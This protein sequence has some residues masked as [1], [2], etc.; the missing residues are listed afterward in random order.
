MTG[1]MNTKV[2]LVRCPRCRLVLPELAEVPVYKC[3]GC[4]AILQAKNR[5]REIQDTGSHAHEED[6]TR[7]NGLEHASEDKKESISSID[8][9]DLDISCERAGSGMDHRREDISCV[10]QS[11]EFLCSDAISCHKNSGSSPEARSHMEAEEDKFREDHNVSGDDDSEHPGD[12]SISSEI[13]LS[14]ELDHHENKLSVPASGTYD[15]ESSVPA[16]G[17]YDNGSSSSSSPKKVDESRYSSE[18]SSDRSKNKSQNCNQMW[19][20]STSFSK[21]SPS[22]DEC[23]LQE[24]ENLSPVAGTDREVGES[25]KSFRSPNAEDSLITGPNDQIS[26]AQSCSGGSFSS[27][28]HMP[29]RAERMEQA[30]EGILPGFQRVSSAD[31]LE[32]MPHVYAR[33]DLGVTL[34][35]P[36]ARNYYAYDGSVS[37]CNETDDQVPNRHFHQFKRNFKDADSNSSKGLPKRDEFMMNHVMSS[38]SDL[39]R[40]PMNS[41]SALPAKKHYATKGSKWHRD[42]FREPTR[43]SHQV[44]SM[45]T[46]ETNEYSQAAY[47]N[48]SSSSYGQKYLPERPNNP[49]SDKMELLRMVRELQDQLNRTQISKGMPHGGFSSRVAKE[50]DQISPHND[51][52]GPQREK[53]PD[54]NYPRYPG[55]YSQDKTRFQQDKVSRMAFSGDA[56]QCRHQV[57]CSC[58]HCCRQEWHY[59]AQMPPHAVWCNKGHSMAQ[60]RHNC[61]SPY[62]S[63]SSSPHYYTGSEFSLWSQDAK[64]DDQQHN[65]Y[66]VKKKLQPAKRHF[67]PIAG[68][69]PI[70]ACYFC[71]KMLQLPAD[72]LL[73]KRRCH[74]LKCNACSK[75][76]K[77]SLENRRHLVQYSPDPITPPPSEVDECSDTIKRRTLA[78]ASG[79]TNA[80]PV[81]C[82]DDYGRSLCRSCSTDAEHSS[83][84]PPFETVN[85]ISDGSYMET[86]K[87]GKKKSIME[88]PESKYKNYVRTFYPAGPEKLFSEVPPEGVSPLH[89][90]MG[91]PSPSRLVYK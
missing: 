62:H 76:L 10:N 18:N 69:S 78:S 83:V 33:T 39:Q 44:K 2:R 3:G 70:I 28:N 23:N 60:P 22:S 30:E 7:K 89:Q 43:H 73:F 61:Y 11:H 19:S 59:S 14:P 55:R 86:K 67:R 87:E 5:K 13:S 63:D 80:E 54:L 35:S 41:S 66:E 38:D 46:M 85:R 29:P 82:S 74:R 81:S 77:F 8:E 20:V 16:S 42:E 26:A 4:G 75:V 88:E 31:T 21:D 32:N 53:Y 50:E 48:G 71:S 56:T 27:D 57:D 91:Y 65:D 36:T 52:F 68:G 58:L 51:F 84:A 72:F 15:N 9:S 90:L 24:I 64:S 1:Q 37:S 47:G 45:M 79:A 40:R 34:R 6:T 49:E 12:T 25:F 17:T